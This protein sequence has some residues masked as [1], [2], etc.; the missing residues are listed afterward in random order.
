MLS[1]FWFVGAVDDIEKATHLARLIIM[2]LGMNPKIGLVNLKRTR[3][4]PQDPYQLYSDATAEV[5]STDPYIYTY[6]PLELHTV[7]S[8]RY[9]H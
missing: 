4:S 3:P 8:K 9:G 5:S 7:T 6:I 1:S 2:Q